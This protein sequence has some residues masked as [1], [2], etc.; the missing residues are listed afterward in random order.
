ME[1]T[2][3]ISL[4]EKVHKTKNVRKKK[5]SS[6]N[7]D[8]QSIEQFLVTIPQ[9]EKKKRNLVSTSIHYPLVKEP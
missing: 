9:T 4:E 1:G 8:E 5:N 7:K 6:K 2:S 3:T